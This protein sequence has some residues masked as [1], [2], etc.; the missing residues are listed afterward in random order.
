MSATLWQ[1]ELDITDQT[2]ASKF[3]WERTS[4]DPVADESWNT[5]SKAIGRKSIELTPADVVGRAVFACHV[6]I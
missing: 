1:G 3:N 2:D 6:D 5:S 4:N